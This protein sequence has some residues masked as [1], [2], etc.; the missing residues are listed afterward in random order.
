[1]RTPTLLLAAALLPL[2]APPAQAEGL[3]TICYALTPEPRVQPSG[4]CGSGDG[5]LT[6]VITAGPNGV[7]ITVYYCGPRPYTSP[8]LPQVPWPETCGRDI[9]P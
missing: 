7:T 3:G 9:R 4:E 6:I 2:A 5:T 1:M 8:S